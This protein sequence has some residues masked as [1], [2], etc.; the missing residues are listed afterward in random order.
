M[1]DEAF[2]RLQGRLFAHDP[3]SSDNVI[4]GRTHRGT[5][6]EINHR[7]AF[8]DLIIGVGE[9]IPHP[10]AGFGGG[11]KIIVPGIASYRSVAD[12][13]FTWMRHRNSRVNLLSGNHFYED[14]VD[15]GHLSRLAF[16][17]D[18][19]INEKKE[20]IRAFSGDPVEEH[21]EAS[22]FAASLYL[23]EMPKLADVTIIS[24]FPLEIGVQASKALDM[25]AF[26]T[27]SGGTI[28]WAAPQKQAGPIMPLIQEMASD[29]TAG[30][31]HR[32]LI[33]G[34]IPEHL[35]AFGISYIMQVVYYKEKAHK[36]DVYHVTQGLSAEQVKMMNFTYAP[37][38]QE[39]VDQVAQKMPR[40]DVAIFPSGGTIIPKVQ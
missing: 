13:H 21:R 38:I 16:K 30:D 36:F 34:D 1:G 6:V 14:M 7:A 32:R 11:C 23:V 12:H 18:L 28:I 27:R 5:L 20:V 22:D 26:C 8:A 39:A 15:A 33:E 31:F 10:V 17:L 24:A 37:T 2:S 19:I 40:A 9:C 25:A 35:Q 4:I 29:E 3:H